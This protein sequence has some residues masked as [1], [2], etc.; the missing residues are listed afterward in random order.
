[1]NGAREIRRMTF[2]IAVLLQHPLPVFQGEPDLALSRIA[3]AFRRLDRSLPAIAMET[4]FCLILFG[5]KMSGS[6]LFGVM[7]GSAGSGIRRCSGYGNT[8]LL[9]ACTGIVCRFEIPD[10]ISQEGLFV[11]TPFEYFFGLRVVSVNGVNAN[12]SITRF[13]MSTDD[14]PSQFATKTK[15]SIFLSSS[16]YLDGNP[17][18]R[19]R[20]ADY[21]VDASLG[22]VEGNSGEVLH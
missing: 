9:E 11:E 2:S 7:A 10:A 12:V 19:V 3:N 4:M 21:H 18:V 22:L 13:A 17:G 16:T 15:K 8:R 1:M 20:G 6:R 14:R 5:G